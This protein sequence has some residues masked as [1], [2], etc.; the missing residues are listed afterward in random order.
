MSE[1]SNSKNRNKSQS[2]DDEWIGELI[3]S[4]AKAAGHLLWWAM[5]FPAI[6]VPII[7]SGIVALR[8]GV[9]AGMV[10]TTAL[11]VGYGVWAWLDARSF[12]AWIV[13]P[14]R[15]RWL[16]WWRYRR[17]WASVCTL[18]GLTAKLGERTLVPVL[19]AVQIGHHTEVL[20]LEW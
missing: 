10:T 18:H 13:A 5:L 11:A 1:S 2:S 16:I 14:V 7:I 17:C 4:L 3:W 15:R 20:D 8:F 9:R 6:S 12:E 19:R